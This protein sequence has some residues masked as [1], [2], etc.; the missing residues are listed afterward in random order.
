M[1]YFNTRDLAKIFGYNDDSYIRRLIS[2]GR[3]KAKKNGREWLVSEEDA[4]NYRTRNAIKNSFKK[5]ISLNYELKLIVDKYLQNQITI[6]GPK[7]SLTSV[8]LTK[9]YKTHSAIILLC[10]EGY[11]EDASVLNRTMFEL[12]ITI[13]Y[14]LKDPTDERAY[15]YYSYDWVLRKKMLRYAEQRPELIIQLEN[16]ITNLKVDDVSIE[17]VN[18]KAK[19]VQEKFKYKNNRW[20]DRTLA[21]MSKE[22]D[23]E[24]HY[25]TMYRL[26][27]QYTH[28]LP[29]VINDYVK[30]T[31]DGYINFSGISENWVEE[32]L[33]MAFDFFSSIFAA[34]CDQYGW[35]AEKE[36]KL[37]FDRFFETMKKINKD[38][39]K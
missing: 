16:R 29:R 6:S 1:R 24:N 7:D 32:D 37:L 28:S 27:S 34:A 21:D 3:I 13:L 23:K 8:T 15:R 5:L 31:D 2:Q 4:S 11:G 12:L 20:S 26:A 35:A 22:V 30:F 18:R 17:E 25:Q 10:Q 39:I 38:V 9:A 14:I 36:L 19:Q 33:I